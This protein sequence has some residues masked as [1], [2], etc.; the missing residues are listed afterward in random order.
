MA[1]S[2]YELRIYNCH[3]AYKFSLEDVESIQVGR[4]RNDLGIAV[5]NLAGKSYDIN[6]FDRDDILEIYRYDDKG[7]S[8]LLGDTCWFLRTYELSIDSECNDTLTLTFY[9]TIHLLTRRYIAW[10]GRTEINGVTSNYPSQML[11]NYDSMLWLLMY[12]NYGPGVNN[13]ILNQ[14]IITPGVPAGNFRDLNTG[15]IGTIASWQIK[16]YGTVLAD[17]ANRRMDINLSVPNNQSTLS[18]TQRFEHIS[19]LQAMQNIA[20][21]STLQGERLYFDIIYTPATNTA[22]ASFRFSTWVN[23]RG[24]NRTTGANLYTVGPTFGNMTG[25]TLLR[26]WNSEAT[27]AYM[28]GA[29]ENET[30][31]YAS[32][33]IDEIQPCPFYPIEIFGQ[34]DFGDATTGVHN[35]PEGVAQ[36]ELLLAQSRP[37][38]T[39]TGT[40]INN[41]DLDFFNNIKPYDKVVALYRDFTTEV[42]L[43]E[44]EI[45]VDNSGEE[46]TITI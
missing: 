17:L 35:P 9:D 25:A 26:D 6:D 45:N 21:V 33:Y 22:P 46:I 37:I 39:L 12:F 14:N 5:I 27:V 11:Q 3:G 23:L 24:S 34:E 42:Y 16:P 19:V 4:K 20:N 18:G 30:R 38:E 43:D 41:D 8:M 29:G 28:A 15:V 10:A 2:N 44:Y 40:I 32:A 1:Q 36:A 13:E 7:N 31:V